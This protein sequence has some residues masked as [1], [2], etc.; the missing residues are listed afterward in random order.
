[1]MFIWEQT[2]LKILKANFSSASGDCLKSATDWGVKL[3]FDTVN[4]VDC[5]F[6]GLKYAFIAKLSQIK[7][8]FLQSHSAINFHVR[9]LLHNICKGYVIQL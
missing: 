7:N 6:K 3:T 9:F 5:Y 1:M 4:L 2:N 8:S